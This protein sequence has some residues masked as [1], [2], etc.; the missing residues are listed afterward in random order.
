MTVV[1]AIAPVVIAAIVVACDVIVV[2]IA[3][4]VISDSQIRLLFF[5]VSSGQGQETGQNDL[6]PNKCI[7]FNASMYNETNS[8][9]Q[10]T[11]KKTDSYHE[12][13]F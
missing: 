12:F 11:N 6:N 7:V 13:H 2:V 4:I 3:V 1:S 8:Q 9:I 5:F 10:L